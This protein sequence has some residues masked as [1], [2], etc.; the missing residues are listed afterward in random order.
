MWVDGGGLEKLN[1][2]AGAVIPSVLEYQ[3][4]AVTKLDE[5]PSVYIKYL[6][7]QETNSVTH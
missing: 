1:G 4:I 2:D 7:F 3:N 5:V 6:D